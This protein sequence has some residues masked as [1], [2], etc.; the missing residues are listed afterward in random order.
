MLRDLWSVSLAVRLISLI[1]GFRRAPRQWITWAAFYLLSGI[2]LRCADI[3]HPWPHVYAYLWY[4]QQAGSALLLGFL[5][6]KV[7]HPTETLVQISA[8]AALVTTGIVSEANHWPGSPTET[9]MWGCGTVT[10]AMGIIS[11]IGA[12][13]EFTYEAGILAGFLILYSALML[14]GSDYLNSVNL[15]IAWSGLEIVAFT[16]WSIL[17]IFR[18][19]D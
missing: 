1:L 16:A 10:L 9:V 17:F 2:A 5:V 6:A 15:G 13:V 3:F 11:V 8:L 18:K 7:I 12:M 14:A 19:H 4:G